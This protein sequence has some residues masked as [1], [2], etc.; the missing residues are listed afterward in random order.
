MRFA[1]VAVFYFL[2]SLAK[3]IRFLLVTAC[4]STIDTSFVFVLAAASRLDS[5]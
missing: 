1:L 4:V 2:F 3:E 5:T